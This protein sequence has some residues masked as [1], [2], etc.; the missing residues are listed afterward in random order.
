LVAFVEQGVEAFHKQIANAGRGGGAGHQIRPC[1]IG[2]LY[3][4]I[5]QTPTKLL[6]TPVFSRLVERLAAVLLNP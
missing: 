2:S 1:K 4:T 3:H 6:H 5:L